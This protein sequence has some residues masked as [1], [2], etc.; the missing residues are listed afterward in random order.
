MKASIAL[1]LLSISLRVTGRVAMALKQDFTVG[2]LTLCSLGTDVVHGIDGIQSSRK[3]V[4]AGTAGMTSPKN[5]S[6]V[7]RSTIF[8]AHAQPSSSW[9]TLS[10]KS[11]LTNLITLNDLGKIIVQ[12]FAHDLLPDRGF[13]PLLLCSTC[14]GHAYLSCMLLSSRRRSS[15]S[16]LLV[17]NDVW[18]AET[19]G[20]VYRRCRPCMVRHVCRSCMLLL[21]TQ[22]GVVMNSASERHQ[23]WAHANAGCS[24]QHS[25]NAL[26]GNGERAKAPNTSPLDFC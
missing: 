6:C 2:F 11:I 12:H 14:F 19:G 9:R 26:R 1:G 8:R 15:S 5:C 20:C 25:T 3:T 4:C 7:C 24:W 17:C 23:C 16:T 18:V 21:P 13:L 10:C 22:Q